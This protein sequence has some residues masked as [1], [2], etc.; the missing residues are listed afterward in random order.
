MSGF[1]DLSPLVQAL[2]A[3]LGTWGLSGAGATLV[4]FTRKVSRRFLDASL[5][6]ELLFDT[7]LARAPASRSE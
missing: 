1:A 5:G 3:T 2:I 4:L 6:F 7:E